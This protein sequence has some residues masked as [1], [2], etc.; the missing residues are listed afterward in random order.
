MSVKKNVSYAQIQKN[1]NEKGR[2]KEK[3]KM[4]KQRKKE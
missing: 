2:E 4:I 1:K 3:R